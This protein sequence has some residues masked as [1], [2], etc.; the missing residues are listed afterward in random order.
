MK[1][2]QEE[3]DPPVQLP[4][5][6]SKEYLPKNIEKEEQSSLDLL[7]P[8]RG[9]HNL[10]VN[11]IANELIAE[12]EKASGYELDQAGKQEILNFV[13]N[14][15]RGPATYMTMICKGEECPFYSHCQPPGSL[16]LT[17]NRG[18]VPIEVLNPEKDRVVTFLRTNS[19]KRN[20]LTRGRKFTL[21]NKEFT[22]NLI[23]IKTEKYNHEITPDHI[24]LFYWNNNALNK[25]VVYLMQKDDKFRIGITKL[26]KTYPSRSN[27]TVFG[28]GSRCSTEGSDKAW[29]LEVHESLS[30]A[31]LAEDRLSCE[32][33]ITKVLFKAT[34][35]RERKKE[36]GIYKWVTQSQLDKHHERCR[37]PLQYYAKVL[38]D[39][40]LDINYPFWEKN[41]N[42]KFKGSI[43]KINEIRSCNLIPSYMDVITV[44][45]IENIKYSTDVHRSTILDIEYNYYSGNVYSLGVSKEET[46]VSQNII[47]HNCPL[48]KAKSKLPYNKPCPVERS[49]MS[50][51]I[52]KHIEALGIENPN[53]PE[54]SFDMDMLFELAGQE[55]IRWRCSLHLSDRPEL[56]EERQVGST[57]T[58][59]PIF[60]D[61]INPVLDI[62]ERAGRNV[63]RIREALLAT[64][65][66]QIKAGKHMTDPS[67]EQSDIKQKVQDLIAKNKSKQAT[68]EITNIS[69]NE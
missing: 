34:T 36:E 28:L 39:R 16:V 10:I 45:D 66:S 25:F 53:S 61:V 12:S 26:L 68:Q 48:V 46:Y 62:M 64:R 23:K 58:G 44:D 47:T 22:G 1:D 35:Y 3:T 51:W 67:K 5:Q 11:S 21:H 13:S 2:F 24:S 65:E 14:V 56:M 55:L 7:V 18:Y 40:N 29:I 8:K 50:T 30:E 49:A 57:V 69:E 41:R 6:A 20:F 15:S 59:D 42:K 33:Q 17:S 43:N 32:L 27:Y 37:K 38:K 9:D 60:A 52:S 4:E 19:K 54:N 31:L 63:H